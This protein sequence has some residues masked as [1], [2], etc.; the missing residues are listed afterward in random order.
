VKKKKSRSVYI[1]LSAG[2]RLFIHSCAL[3]G[4]ITLFG[5]FFFPLYFSSVSMFKAFFSGLGKFWAGW[6]DWRRREIGWDWIV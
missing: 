6:D 5:G 1:L 4:K 2:C 3:P